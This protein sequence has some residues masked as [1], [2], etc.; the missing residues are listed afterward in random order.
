MSAVVSAL[1]RS[2]ATAAGHAESEHGDLV[3]VLVNSRSAVEA[4]LAVVMLRDRMSERDLVSLCNLRELIAV[5]PAVPFTAPSE[6]SALER[7]LGYERIGASF[8]LVVRRERA[9][10]GLEFVG[11]GNRVD[12]IV[13]HAENVRI[14]LAIHDGDFI[15]PAAID[16]LLA[17]EVLGTALVDALHALGVDISP[18]FY[19]SVTDY[20]LE[21]TVAVLDDIGGLF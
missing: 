13:L 2:L 9:L 6:L 4:S 14:P 3:R 11:D 12:S 1:Q 15:D 7:M 19:M 21:N 18:K 16:A 8:S 20:V 17:D 5:L 10:W